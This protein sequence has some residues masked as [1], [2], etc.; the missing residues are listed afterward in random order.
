MHNVRKG[1]VRLLNANFFHLFLL[2]N[3][4]YCGD[5]VVALS[6]FIFFPTYLLLVFSPFY[7]VGYTFLNADVIFQR[8]E[9][10]ARISSPFGKDLRFTMY[11]AVLLCCYLIF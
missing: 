4:L 6:A 3:T 11:Q 9:S 8:P 7:V 5:V 1:N 10:Y 2:R